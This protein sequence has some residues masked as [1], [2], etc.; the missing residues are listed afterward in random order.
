MS[1]YCNECGGSGIIYVYVSCDGCYGNDP[2]C[3]ICG[4]SG[5][6]VIPTPCPNH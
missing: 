6:A 5:T 4:G 3:S 1:D 2:N